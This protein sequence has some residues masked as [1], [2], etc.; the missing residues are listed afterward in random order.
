MAVGRPGSSAL[1]QSHAPMRPRPVR[2]LR[3][4]GHLSRDEPSPVGTL[5]SGPTRPRSRA[6]SHVMGG[7]GQ[8]RTLD[9]ALLGRTTFQ[10]SGP[11]IGISL[12]SKW[13]RERVTPVG[14][15]NA[16][17]IACPCAEHDQSACRP[18]SSRR[19]GPDGMANDRV[20]IIDLGGATSASNRLLALRLLSGRRSATSKNPGDRGPPRESG[21]RPWPHSG[22]EGHRS[23]QDP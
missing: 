1:S 23:H 13:V 18:L 4:R 17:S 20:A 2:S 21:R 5:G 6:P 16:C 3:G 22:H 9:Q 19:E 10:S 15:Q 11:S 12:N 14:R 8:L 7:P